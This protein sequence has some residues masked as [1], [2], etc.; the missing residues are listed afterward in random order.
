MNIIWNELCNCSYV[1]KKML[2]VLSFD[3]MG[4]K[5]NKTELVEKLVN[6]KG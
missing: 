5:L 6:Q 1:E 3:G 2:L 4:E